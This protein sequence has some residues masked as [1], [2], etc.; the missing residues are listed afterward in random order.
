MFHW[1]DYLL[2]PY[3]MEIFMTI[4]SPINDFLIK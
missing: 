2:L 4:R 1:K 3:R